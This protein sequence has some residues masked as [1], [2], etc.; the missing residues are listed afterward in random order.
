MLILQ[1]DIFCLPECHLN[2]NCGDL[3]LLVSKLDPWAACPMSIWCFK[4]IHKVAML[5]FWTDTD[6]IYYY[7]CWQVLSWSLV[8]KLSKLIFPPRLWLVQLEQTL[9]MRSCSLLLAPRYAFISL[10]LL[11]YLFLTIC[12]WWCKMLLSEAIKDLSTDY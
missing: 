10:L 4:S 8:Q 9:H 11:M 1:Y 3:I 2:R 7:I 5:C 12:W 6:H